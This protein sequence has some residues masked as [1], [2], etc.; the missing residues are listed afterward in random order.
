MIY[1]KIFSPKS[2]GE[3]ISLL[4]MN[5]GSVVKPITWAID[6]MLQLYKE[7]TKADILVDSHDP[8]STSNS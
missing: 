3:A 4:N 7:I 6:L 2:L 5:D 8:N 1:K